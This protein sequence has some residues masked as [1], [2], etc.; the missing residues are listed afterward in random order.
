MTGNKLILASH[1]LCPYVQRAAIALTEKGVPFERRDVDF[2]DKPDWFLEVSPLGKTPVLIVDGHPI[3]ESAVILEYLEDAYGP[4]MHP[5]DPLARA[6]H[7]AWMEFGSAVLDDIAGFYNAPDKEVI[8]RK[9]ER[10]AERFKQ[11]EGRLQYGPYFAGER[12]CLVD[13]VFG[14]VFRYFDVFDRITDFGIFD[15][16]S[17]TR[18]WREKLA[19]RQNIKLAVGDDYNTRL[20]TF[21]LGRGSRLSQILEGDRFWQH[22]GMPSNHSASHLR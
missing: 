21:I 6:D 3:F 20:C 1:H 15:G 18:S 4:P 19:A 14:P 16:K 7:R 8:I 5:A 12:F 13:A 2:S 22:A 17:K 9:A 10:L 11:V